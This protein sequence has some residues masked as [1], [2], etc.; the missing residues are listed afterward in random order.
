M[1]LFKSSSKQTQALELNP[2]IDP[3]AMEQP[4]DSAAYLRRGYAFYG[5]QRFSDASEDFKK[6]IDLDPNAVDAV[7][8]L[9]M[10]L[11]AAG[12]KAAAASAFKDAIS[13]IDQGVVTDKSRARILRR[14]AFGHF[15]E[16]TS[17]DW[18]LETEIW[19]HVG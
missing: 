12:E 10:S 5:V 14:L 1:K 8:A 7:Y 9:G 2:P 3:E 18:N 15:N 13:L 11:K 6:A 19:Q 16:I 4:T 17:G